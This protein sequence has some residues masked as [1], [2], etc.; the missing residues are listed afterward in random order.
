MEISIKWKMCRTCRQKETEAGSAFQPLFESG[1]QNL[2]VLY[3]GVVV[4]PHD[5]LPDQICSDCVE[6][7]ED[8]DRFLSECKQSDD[9][10]RDLVR[11]T[12]SSAVALHTLE[13]KDQP[14]GPRKRARKQNI[15]AR[16]NEEKSS[17]FKTDEGQVESPKSKDKATE[18]ESN[19]FDLDVNAKN[20]IIT[21]NEDYSISSLKKESIDHN[22][23]E[24]LSQ[25]DTVTIDSIQYTSEE[26][27]KSD[28][29]IE[30]EVDL[31]VAC[32]PDKFICRICSNTYPRMCQLTVHMKVHRTEKIHECEVCQKSFKA[33]CN[34]KTHMRIHTGEKPYHCSY[35][36]RRFA[37]SSTHRKH[38]RMHT[39]E[40]PYACKICGKTFSL[41][42]SRKAHYLLHSSEKP[43]KCV[44]CN[45]AFRLKHQLT[46]HEKTDAHLLGV[47]LAKEYSELME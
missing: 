2:L 31:G 32:V 27:Q 26:S 18:E 12:M 15:S 6:R 43:H 11:Q 47:S 22:D 34:L 28:S 30:Y 40:K 10:L 38:E 14:S 25:D 33:A 44:T 19:D 21:I 7:L 35:C 41:S 8:V 24:I 4:E 37:D 17:I 9:Y 46:A 1:A 13:I 23:L 29:A 36:V 45:K 42:T 39:N 5:G 16:L 3:A 20:E